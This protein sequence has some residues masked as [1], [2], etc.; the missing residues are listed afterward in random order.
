MGDVFGRVELYGDLLQDFMQALVAVEGEFTQATQAGDFKTLSAQM[1]TL[2]GT[3]ATLGAMPLSEHAAKLEQKFRNP[4]QNLVALDELPGLLALVQ[5]TTL[6]ARA[7]VPGLRATAVAR[8]TA[9]SAGDRAQARELLQ[10]LTELLQ[11]GDLSS[12]DLFAQQRDALD[13]LSADEVAE[14][15]QALQALDLE[16]ARQLC[17]RHIASLADH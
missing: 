5:S 15:H 8:V 14:L 16:L 12:L 3:A 2:K 4:P 11:V 9:T 1:H 17:E 10:G 13:A 6:A 7:A